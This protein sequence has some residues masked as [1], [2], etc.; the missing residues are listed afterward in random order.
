M[1]EFRLTSEANDFR[2]R[3]DA[4]TYALVLHHFRTQY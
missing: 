1:K 2:L 4:T 3:N